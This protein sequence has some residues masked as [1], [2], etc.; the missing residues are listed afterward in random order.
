MLRSSLSSLSPVSILLLSKHQTQ[1]H[2]H[3]VLHK[4]LISTTLYTQTN[5]GTRLG[6]LSCSV[7][8]R[9]FHDMSGKWQPCYQLH[10]KTINMF[11]FHQ[12][13]IT[14]PTFNSSL[15]DSW[16]T[17]LC[18]QPFD[19]FAFRHWTETEG[20]VGGVRQYALFSATNIINHIPPQN[21]HDRYS[22]G[23]SNRGGGDRTPVTI[24]LEERK[25]AV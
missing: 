10:L 21:E 11:I 8:A 3:S 18:L 23:Q 6:L 13:E 7:G 25:L 17:K 2:F 4:S 19:T 24:H 14:N 15:L 16:Y 12:N 22:H 20:A 5:Q 1:T 9:S